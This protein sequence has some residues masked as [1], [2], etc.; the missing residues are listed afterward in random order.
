[1]AYAT[2]L[3]VLAAFCMLTVIGIPFG[4]LLWWKARK[5]EKEKEQA[6]EQLKNTQTNL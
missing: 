1:M 4:I 3:R 2:G 6:Y 5:V